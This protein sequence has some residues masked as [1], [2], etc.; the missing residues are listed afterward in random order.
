MDIVTAVLRREIIAVIAR[1]GG[2]L[3]SFWALASMLKPFLFGIPATDGPTIA[4]VMAALLCPR[5]RNVSG[6]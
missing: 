2:G 3:G 1:L 6:S 5:E 4:G